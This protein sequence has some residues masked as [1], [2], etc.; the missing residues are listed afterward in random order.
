MSQI[1]PNEVTNSTRAFITALIANTA[2]LGVEVG[3]FLFLKQR[4]KRIYSPRTYLPPPEKR[5]TEFPPGPWQWLPSLINSRAEDIMDKNGLDAYMFL[6]FLKMLVRIFFV[7]TIVTFIIIVPVNFVGQHGASSSLEK[8]TWTNI[9]DADQQPRFLAHILVVYLLTFYVIYQIRLEMSHFVSL[10][11]QFLLSPAHSRLAQARTVLITSVPDTISTESAIRQFASFVPGGV[12]RVWLYRDTKNLNKVFNE[13]NKRCTELEKAL[14]TILRVALKAWG[15]RDEQRKKRKAKGIPKPR[16]GDVEAGEEEGGGEPLDDDERL[17]EQEPSM[18]LLDELVPLSKRPKTRTGTL[19]LLGEKVDTLE[20]CKTDIAQLNDTIASLRASTS[21]DGKF[22]G[23]VFILCNLQIGAHILAQC[24][25]RNSPNDIVWHNL[26]DDALKTRSKVTLSWLITIGMIMLYSVPVAAVGT[27]SNLSGLC[28]SVQWL[29]WV[30][31][32]PKSVQGIIQ[33]FLPP[34]LLAALFAVV[35]YVLK[36]LAWYEGLPRNSLISVSLYRRFFLFLLIHGFLVVTLSS[37]LIQVI[38]QIID[39]P[40][41][42]VQTLAQKLP[43]ASVF[44]LTYMGKYPFFFLSS[45]TQGLAGAGSALAQLFPLVGYYFGKWFMGRTP[46]QAFDVTFL[47]PSADFGTLL[48]SISLLATIGLA[49][50]TLNPLINLLALHM[51]VTILR[52]SF[53]FDQPV[54]KESG[55]GYFPMAAS[56][57]FVGLYIEQICL[58][59]LFFL[60]VPLPESRF[61]ALIQGVLML[62]LLGITVWANVLLNRGY[63][64]LSQFIPMSLA[65]KDLA[66][67][68]RQLEGQNGGRD[69]DLFSQDFM[70]T[71]RKR[72]GKKVDDNLKKPFKLQSGV[73]RTSPSASSSSIAHATRS[74]DVEDGNEGSSE[75]GA[76]VT[77]SASSATDKREESGRGHS[78]G[79]VDTTESGTSD[80]QKNAASDSRTQSEDLSSSPP[81]SFEDSLDEHA[82]DHPST[83]VDQPCIWIPRDPLGLSR[84]LVE[85]LEGAGIRA[86]DEGATLGLK[87]VVEVTRP[88]PTG[89]L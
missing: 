39:N 44:F 46:R 27:L 86:S 67:R 16:N 89:L 43:G 3:L 14:S 25:Y 36:G 6:R 75:G 87:G 74:R 72:I 53:V 12:E 9:A 2:L 61:V 28:K 24:V 5:S 21:S 56:N 18:K 26:D 63:A 4:L 23:S 33:G 48:P 49:Y 15:K 13:R 83:Y 29:E 45:I 1:N 51:G 69:L 81:V 60:K 80:Y 7:F 78:P 65:T 22:L 79:E 31:Q 77:A 84:V 59:S 17:L 85:Y 52:G 35:P 34:V 19:G 38:E 66:E 11:Q 32:L 70:K 41:R 37:G 55:G 54:S 30:C 88:P 10:R 62:V 20:W 57:L 42:A 71:I 8:I 76:V 68:F 82:F 64:P 58:A 73:G 40:T 50:S 47:M